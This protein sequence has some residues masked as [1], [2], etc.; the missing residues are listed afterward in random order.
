[1]TVV[2][3]RLGRKGENSRDNVIRLLNKVLSADFSYQDKLDALQNEFKISVSKEMSEEGA[4]LCNLSAGVYNKGYD[5]GISVGKMKKAKSTAY[6]LH[7]KG[8][9]CEE[10]ADTIEVDIDTVCDWLAEREE[11]LVK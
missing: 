4:D 6:K 7:D 5:S 9:P 3:L 1:M 2:V 11:M 8:M 10:I